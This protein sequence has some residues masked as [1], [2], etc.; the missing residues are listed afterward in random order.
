MAPTG[1]LFGSQQH[2]EDNV[3]ASHNHAGNTPCKDTQFGQPPNQ[4]HSPPGY[5]YQPS[6]PPFQ[7]APQFYNPASL[8]IT[9]SL[10]P[11]SGGATQGYQCYGPS[12][13]GYNF[14][15]GGDGWPQM[16]PPQQFTGQG[17]WSPGALRVPPAQAGNNPVNGLTLSS[18]T[19]HGQIPGAPGRPP[20]S[21]PSKR[22]QPAAEPR[23]TD[24]VRIS[25]LPPSP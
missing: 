3:G 25:D 13:Q 1:G 21:L 23:Q 15:Q 2:P 19:P 16:I 22:F 6:Q 17:P 11:S 14:P 12:L 8:N 4:I 7:G 5:C 20:I 9:P 10:Q 24:V 18:S